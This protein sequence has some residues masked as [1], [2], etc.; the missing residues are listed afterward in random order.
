MPYFFQQIIADRPGKT[1]GDIV[2]DHIP[3]ADWSWTIFTLIYTTAAVTVITNFMN[4]AVILEGLV[5]YSIVTW[6]RMLSI[7]LFTLEPPKDIV[8]LIDPF[9]T[10]VVYHQEYFMKDLFFSGHISS[11]MVFVLIEPRPVLRWVKAS[12][13]VVV[14]ILILVQHV[15]YTLDVVAAPI[16]TY[17]VYVLVRRFKML[18]TN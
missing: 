15:H 12:V 17:G 18:P 9:L 1:M 2:L 8:V 5:N 7:F 14:A 11:M 10:H 13:T 6:L 3:A 16:I 4:P